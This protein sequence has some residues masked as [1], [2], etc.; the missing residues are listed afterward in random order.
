MVKV[1]LYAHFRVPEVWVVDL[2]NDRLHFYRSPVAGDYSM[3]S[4]TS[5]PGIT[6]VAG[7]PGLAIDLSKLF[8]R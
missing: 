4:S 3:V 1:P 6:E 7:L 2:M 8:R 5:H